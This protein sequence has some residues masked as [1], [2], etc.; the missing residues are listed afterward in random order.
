MTTVLFGDENSGI[1]IGSNQGPIYLPGTFLK[2]LKTY[3]VE[4][5]D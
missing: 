4:R 3:P 2:A 1:Q 5:G